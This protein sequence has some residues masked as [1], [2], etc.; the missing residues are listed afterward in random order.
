MQAPLQ[1]LYTP[2]SIRILSLHS[3]RH[4]KIDKKRDAAIFETTIAERKK[5]LLS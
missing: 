3:R 2:T 5:N 1:C 4:I